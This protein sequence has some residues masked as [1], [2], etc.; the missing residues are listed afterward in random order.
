MHQAFLQSGKRTASANNPNYEFEN[1]NPLSSNINGNN[2]LLSDNGSM[3]HPGKMQGVTYKQG[4][5][6]RDQ[7]MRFPQ[8][9]QFDESSNAIEGMSNSFLPQLQNNSGDNGM[10][11]Q[12]MMQLYQNEGY[13]YT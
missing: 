10:G 5:M 7:Q 4:L 12:Q 9:S 8:Q 2:L 1:N 13:S 11:G 3:A 6:S